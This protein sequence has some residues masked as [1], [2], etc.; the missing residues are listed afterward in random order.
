MLQILPE[1]SG[2]AR[3]VT[4]LILK[5]YTLH[6]YGFRKQKMYNF[7]LLKMY[8]HFYSAQNHYITSSKLSTQL[9]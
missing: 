1:W 3:G 9:M 8:V 4:H 6:I 5:L 2:S 7:I